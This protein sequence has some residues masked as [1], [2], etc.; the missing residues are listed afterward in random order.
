M[1]EFASAAMVRVLRQGMRDLGLD[2]DGVPGLPAPHG[3]LVDLALKRHLVR[4]A[5]QKGGLACL[6]LLGRGLHRH[7]HEPTHRA[8][9]SAADAGDLLARWRRLERYIHSNHRTEVV[10]F[11]EGE[12]VLMHVA[13][14]GCEPPQ[15]PEDLVV[16][17]VLAAL[18]QAIGCTQV[19][20]FIGR[21]PVFPLPDGGAL[22]RIVRR[23]ASERW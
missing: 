16:L 2:P 17:G 11:E 15:P 9:C 6:P 13:A 23:G 20:V 12:A 5:L 4:S 22:Q 8:L 1:S 21:A 18:L 7:R 14:P 19:E 3:A 10:T